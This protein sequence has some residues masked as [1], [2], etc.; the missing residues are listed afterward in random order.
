MRA[1]DSVS[2]FSTKSKNTVLNRRT[3]MNSD[4][5]SRQFVICFTLNASIFFLFFFTWSD[6]VPVQIWHSFVKIWV[7]GE[8]ITSCESR[9]LLTVSKAKKESKFISNFINPLFPV[10]SLPGQSRRCRQRHT[11]EKSNEACP[12]LNMT[13][14]K[15][16]LIL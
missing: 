16:K 4:C 5:F 1:F 13:I 9:D 12:P 14:F 11:V 3:T 15:R 6:S 10:P 2:P 8:N 7:R